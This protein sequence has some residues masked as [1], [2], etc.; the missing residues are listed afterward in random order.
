M[1]KLNKIMVIFAAMAA[2][3]ELA[4]MPT[5][6]SLDG[7]WDFRL[8]AGRHIEQVAGL[9][10]FVAN[11]RMIVPGAWD[12]M[13]RYYNKRGTGCYR[14]KFTLDQNL[15]AARLVVGGLYDLCRRPKLVVETVRELFT[16]KKGD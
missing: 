4:A 8:E 11:D 3:L 13:S 10:A 1:N 7:L 14:R 16:S 2:G 6:A 9:P 12:A 15:T 5:T